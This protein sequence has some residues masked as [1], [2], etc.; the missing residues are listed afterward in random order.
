MQSYLHI[1]ANTGDSAL[2]VDEQRR[3]V[4]WNHAAEDAFGYSA[5]EALGQ[6]C[7][8]LLN[9][10]TA[11]GD[12]FCSLDCPIINWIQ[13]GK[14]VKHFNLIARSRLGQ[15]V[16]VNISAI[17]LPQEYQSTESPVLVQLGRLLEIQ[18]KSE[19]LLRIHLLGPIAVWR[20]DGR[21]VEGALWRRL[22]VRALLAFLASHH[23]HPISREQLTDILWRELPYEAA[24]RNL[25]T[26]IYNLRHC[27]EPDLQ[28][29]AD[30]R[31]VIYEGGFYRL[32]DG[33]KLWL[34]I[35][36]FEVQIRQARFAQEAADAI[37]FYQEALALYRGDYLSD[38]S[39]TAVWSP[40]EHERF[41]HLYLN[42][43]EEL[44]ALY[45]ARHDD[46]AAKELYLRALAVDPCREMTCQKLI[47]L[48]L[49]QGDVATAVTQCRHLA[50]SMMSELNIPPSQET[51]DL[52]RHLDC[53][54]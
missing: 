48:A 51:L 9:G 6:F 20:P 8:E 1:F 28:N 25:N 33:Q 18:N 10:R 50:Q 52:C 34:D 44:G 21:P 53:L 23:R 19:S 5:E 42:A 12:P 4:Y 15:D 13:Q 37:R 2:A 29:G 31:Y 17:P 3:I 41:R 32:A 40:G 11:N 24:L 43:A 45:E 16:V 46:I 38:L 7:W 49:R 26:T 36:L 30:S 14:P 35:E 47:R 27:L 39:Q 54:A 22:K